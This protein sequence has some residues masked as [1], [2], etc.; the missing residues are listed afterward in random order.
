MAKLTLQNLDITLTDVALVD[1]LGTSSVDLLFRGDGL[2]FEDRL[3]L[4][5]LNIAGAIIMGSHGG[6]LK[7]AVAVAQLVVIGHGVVSV[8][9]S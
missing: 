5:S 2:Q 9:C 7:M 8:L 6:D 3:L 4:E 1:S